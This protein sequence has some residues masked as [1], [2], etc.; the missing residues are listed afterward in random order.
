MRPPRATDQSAPLTVSTSTGPG[1]SSR[2]SIAAPE[3]ATPSAA[4]RVA[5]LLAV[6]AAVQEKTARTRAAVRDDMV[7]DLLRLT[8]G[9]LQMDGN[10]LTIHVTIQ[11]WITRG[12]TGACSSG[13]RRRAA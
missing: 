4:G 11:K 10:R 5:W 3:L 7:D 12:K 1:W 6:Q 2:A 9:H 8:L 13:W